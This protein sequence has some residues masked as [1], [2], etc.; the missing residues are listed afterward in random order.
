MGFERGEFSRFASACLKES[1]TTGFVLSP[2]AT[3][4]LPYLASTQQKYI[5]LLLRTQQFCFYLKDKNKSTHKP[6]FK[7]LSTLICRE[8]TYS[9]LLIS[10][11]DALINAHNLRSDG[12]KC[13]RGVINFKVRAAEDSCC[14]SGM[15]RRN[16]RHNSAPKQRL[17]TLQRKTP[18]R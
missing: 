16:Q 4:T 12:E 6:T 17:C 18:K 13:I 2:S 15:G 9:P 14:Y 11:R 5:Q 7:L 10:I 3:S 8:G 1:H